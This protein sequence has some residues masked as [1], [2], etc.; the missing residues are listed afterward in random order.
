M[1]P[2]KVKCNNQT[3]TV[4]RTKTKM[5]CFAHIYLFPPQNKD[6]AKL[7]SMKHQ[8]SNGHCTINSQKFNLAVAMGLHVP[9]CSLWWCKCNSAENLQWWKSPASG[10]FRWLAQDTAAREIP[11]YLREAR[12]PSWL[13]NMCGRGFI[14]SRILILNMHGSYCMSDLFDVQASAGTTVLL[15]FPSLFTWV[16]LYLTTFGRSP[17]AERH[18]AALQVSDLG[19][20]KE[21]LFSLFSL[22]SYHNIPGF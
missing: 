1:K 8:R 7:V 6:K 15:E 3:R 10:C 16:E 4:T 14:Y 5:V 2:S 21:R 11:L 20:D 18:T 22:F 9:G 13:C 12:C 19:T 17:K